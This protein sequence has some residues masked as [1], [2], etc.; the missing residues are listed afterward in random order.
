LSYTCI[1]RSRVTPLVDSSVSFGTCLNYPRAI[2]AVKRTTR[3]I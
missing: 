1:A 3:G 2:N